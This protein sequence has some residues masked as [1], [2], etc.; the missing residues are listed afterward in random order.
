[1]AQ[2]FHENGQVGSALDLPALGPFVP[3][4][5]TAKEKIG[6][7]LRLLRQA[8]VESR[9][10]TG[11][12]FYSIRAVA[13]H[14]SL[15]PTTVTRLY[16]QLK[17]E[18]VLGSIWG[19]KTII[20]PLEI[21]RDIRLRAIVGLPVALATFSVSA[22]YRQFFQLMQ[23]ALWKQ[24]FGSRLIFHDNGFAESPRFARLLIDYG[25]DVV[26]WLMPPA[27]SCNAAALLKDRGIRF[28][29]I[30]EGMPLNGNS[31]YYLSWQDALVQ[32]LR[33]WRNCG[34]RRAL[35]VQDTQSN[36]S[37]LR[38]V[39]SC[40]TENGFAFDMREASDLRTD[41]APW[42]SHS[43]GHPVIFLS[44]QS[45]MQFEHT[46]VGALDLTM[47]HSRILFVHGS[48]DS[49][50]QRQ[51]NRSFDTITF[52]WRTI[53]RRIVSDIVADRCANHREVQII[54][55]AKWTARIN[56]KEAFPA[57]AA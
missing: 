57:R 52:D 48:M 21:D 6:L 45:L 2:L 46:G 55:R 50:F 24:R 39:Q 16:A 38:L 32:C 8:A 37:A 51:Q 30:I 18:G 22:S 25:V 28:I 5:N 53:T 44:P 19:S 27:R 41:Q 35:V 26:M 10:S 54:F 13:K 56:R 20:E 1:M 15:P 17:V 40:L 33:D 42:Q 3:S 7:V 47:R 9:K 11:Q 4:N 34:E 43:T 14:F 49:P 12:P 36:S 29:P 23:Q 31:G